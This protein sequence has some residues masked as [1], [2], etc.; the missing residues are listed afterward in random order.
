MIE[1]CHITVTVVDANHV[2]AAIS[3]EFDL[4]AGPLVTAALQPHLGD[5]VTIDLADVTFMDSSALQCLL[6][7][8]TEALAQGGRL[9]AGSMSPV[10]QRVLE[11]CAFDGAL[12]SP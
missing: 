1:S 3:G 4:H 12:F 6:Q 5:L 8:H 2:V 9:E 7:L 11:L 10:V